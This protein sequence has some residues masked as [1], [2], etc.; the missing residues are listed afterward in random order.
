MH[1]FADSLSLSHEQA[2]APWRAKVYGK[3]FPGVG[4]SRG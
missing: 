2:N 1:S 3:A 4:Y